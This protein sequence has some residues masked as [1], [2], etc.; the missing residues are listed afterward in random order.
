MLNE[1][2]PPKKY[3]MQIASRKCKLVQS[4]K[5]NKGLLGVGLAHRGGEAVN[6][7]NGLQES[8]RKLLWVID[9]FINLTVAM[10]HTYIKTLRIVHSAMDQISK[11]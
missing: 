9:A 10:V 8:T 1:T 5:A 3:T 2:R 4:N 7:R 6:E 11:I